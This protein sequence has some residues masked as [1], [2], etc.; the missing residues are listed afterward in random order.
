VYLELVRR[1]LAGGLRCLVLVPEI[2]LTPQTRHR[3]EEFLGTPVSVLHSSLGAKEKRETWQALLS[4][5]V[6]ILMGTRSAILA[7]FA[8]QLIILDEEHDSSYKQ[9][10]PAPR[11]HC[12]EMAFHIAHK[13]GALVLLG[14]ATPSAETWSFAQAGHLKLV[15]LKTRPTGAKLPTVRL[16]DMKQKRRLQDSDLMLSPALREELTETVKQGKQAI[17]LHNRR[18]FSTSRVCEACGV[19]IECVACKVP[20]VYHKQHG[21]LLCHYCGRVYP[22]DTPCRFCGGKKFVFLG[23]GIEKAEQEILEWVPGAKVLRMDY[24]SVQRVGAHEALLSRFRNQ[25]CNVLLGTQMVAKGHDFPNVALVGVLNADAS[26]IPDFRADE[27]NF[28]LLAQVAGRAGRSGTLGTVI[29]QAFCPE[30]PVL[31]FALEHDYLGF[32]KYDAEQRQEA[33]YPPFC[34]IAEIELLGAHLERVEQT[35]ALLGQAIEKAGATVLGPAEAFVPFV[36]GKHIQNLL[37]KAPKVADLRSAIGLALA[38]AD[39]KAALKGLALKLD[40]DA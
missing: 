20:L 18:G 1:A 36:N 21:G 4:G 39:V 38:D 35:A 8:P 31:R 16:V 26:A 17:V 14:S 28:Q 15:S 33:L 11:Y 25:E 40:I 27:R 5:R 22:T 13:H 7:P 9:R 37:V 3:F 34:H 10:D 29:L 12:R 32:A 30:N 24:D 23:G 2:G 19:P 6:Q